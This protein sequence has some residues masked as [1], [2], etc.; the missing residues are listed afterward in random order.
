MEEHKRMD[1]WDI[2]VLTY[3]IKD[4]CVLLLSVGHAMEQADDHK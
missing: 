2:L 4:L 3:A 1:E